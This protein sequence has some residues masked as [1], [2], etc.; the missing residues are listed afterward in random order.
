MNV[1]FS[2][3]L[4]I[5]SF[6]KRE[7]FATFVLGVTILILSSVIY[8]SEALNPNPSAGFMDF[9][10]WKIKLSY[11]LHHFETL[12]GISAAVGAILCIAG[13]FIKDSK[14]FK[15]WQF[16]LLLFLV[17]VCTVTSTLKYGFIRD[18]YF[19]VG[20]TFCYFLGPKY[21]K[22][23]G[24]DVHYECAAAA[25]VESGSR[26][27]G[28]GRDLRSNDMRF[29]KS[30]T[31]SE[32]RE[33]CRSRFSE[34]RWESYKQEVNF[35]RDRHDDNGWQ[36]RF[37]DHGYNGTPIYQAFAGLI[38]NSV[39]LNHRNMVLLSLLN[40]WMVFAMFAM[41]INAF[42]WRLGLLFSLFFFSNF[43]ERWLLG[44]AYLRYEWITAVVIGLS[45]MKLGKYH[46]AGGFLAFA[47]GVKIFPML[48]FLG[49]SATVV[50]DLISRRV[51]LPEYKSF[52]KGAFITG[53]ILLIISVLHGQGFE[54]WSQF[55]HQMN[56]NSGRYT[57]VRVGF[58]YNFLWPKKVWST[59]MS[60]SWAFCLDNMNKPFFLFL[61]LNHIR[62]ILMGAFL[63]FT[64]KKL[65]AMDDITRTVFVGFLTFFLF[66]GTVRYYYS[67][68]LGLPLMWHASMDN[69]SGKLFFAYL[70]VVSSLGYLARE[71]TDLAF[72][73]NTFYPTVLTVY[74]VAYLV[75]LRFKN[76]HNSVNLTK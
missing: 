17:L 51:I 22:E 56:L 73:Y 69:R 40:L 61:T 32:K 18:L 68:F 43:L 75:F 28:S 67:G 1:F 44:G 45:F 52:F 29:I 24:Y 57:D 19:D 38:A 14:R 9:F 71:I 15:Q 58:V 12:L 37:R 23:L 10:G 49:I 13:V 11:K 36:R 7:T 31:K 76:D 27:A 20:D 63:F 6:K 60:V 26:L 4:N 42:G 25:Q 70:L 30:L 64:F 72:L 65:R 34:A 21:F 50:W 35:F 5:I 39:E 53:A 74:F 8:Y 41:V 16:G 54:N 46:I 3:L 59:D 48:L 62:L 66:F 33:A 2:S 47:A 55:L